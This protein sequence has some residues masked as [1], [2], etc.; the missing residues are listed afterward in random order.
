MNID[1]D[2]YID[3]RRPTITIFGKVYDV[4]NDYKKVLGVFGFIDRLKEDDPDSVKKFLSYA[5]MDGENAADDILSHNMPFPLF[6]KL[7][8]AIVAA[9]TGREMKEIERAMK[10]AEQAPSFPGA[11]AGGKGK[12]V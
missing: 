2:K 6:E 7:Q 4:D 12:R 8:A 5:L 3:Q 10:Q 1:L 11:N 9:M